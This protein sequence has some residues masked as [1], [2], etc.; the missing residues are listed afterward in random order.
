MRFRHFGAFP[1]QFGTTSNAAEVEPLTLTLA[2]A[3]RL[4]WKVKKLAC[5]FS[6]TVTLDSTTETI[7]NAY[8]VD[9]SPFKPRRTRT[10]G[11]GFIDD[12]DEL[13]LCYPGARAGVASGD[14]ARFDFTTSQAAPTPF[15]SG[16]GVYC[17]PRFFTHGGE[18]TGVNRRGVWQ[19]VTVKPACNIAFTVE[20]LTSGGTNGFIYA[21]NI[22]P[23]TVT[24]TFN[25]TVLGH[26]VAMK[27]QVT[28][29]D[30]PGLTVNAISLSLSEDSVFSYAA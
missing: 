22:S 26:T 16:V 7:N 3:T 23:G 2:E 12:G 10:G 4:W 13:R 18:T 30:F 8:L 24:G 19:G 21:S 28:E 1:F 20:F 17:N 6:V 25:A 11:S 5:T 15:G 9:P 29:G 27:Y 14:G